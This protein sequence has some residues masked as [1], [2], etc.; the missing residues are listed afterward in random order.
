MKLQTSCNSPF[1]VPLPPL[2][3]SPFP[4]FFTLS[5]SFNTRSY[6]FLVNHRQLCYNFH[7][8]GNHFP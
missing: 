2:A 5:F 7:I 3:R 4:S 1:F 8:L 6:I